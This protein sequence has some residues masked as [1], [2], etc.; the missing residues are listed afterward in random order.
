MVKAYR[1]IGH[2]R[3][4]LKTIRD[5]SGI[6]IGDIKRKFTVKNRRI[7]WRRLIHHLSVLQFLGLITITVDE[8]QKHLMDLIV[9]FHTVDFS[10]AK[11]PPSKK[12]DAIKK[13]HCFPT[14]QRKSKSTR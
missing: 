12:I 14:D 2:R 10:S 13:I 1:I 9:E 5:K 3:F 4:I 7:T 8:D 11:R 6:E